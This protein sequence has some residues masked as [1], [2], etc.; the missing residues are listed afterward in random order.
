MALT[1]A[2]ALV[3]LEMLLERALAVMQVV[4]LPVAESK[5]RRRACERQ[6]LLQRGSCKQQ[7]ESVQV[8]AP[9]AAATAAAAAVGRIQSHHCFHRTAVKVLCA[10]RQRV[11]S[12]SSSSSSSSSRTGDRV[13]MF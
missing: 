13:F 1:A 10:T 12:R 4:L 9:A 6:L 2:A 11:G 3:L 8:C 5:W 7:N